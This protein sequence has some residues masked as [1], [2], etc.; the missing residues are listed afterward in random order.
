MLEIKNLHIETDNIKLL[1]GL[2][3]KVNKNEI[4]ILMGPNG[5]GKSTLCKTI[6]GHPAYKIIEG[7]IL[8]NGQNLIDLEIEKRANL[9]IFMGFQY[10]IEIPNTTNYAFLHKT[11]N[12]S[13]KSKNKSILSKKEFEELIDKKLKIVHLN[14]DFLSRGINEG[15]SGGEKKKFELLQMLLLDPQLIILDEIDSGLDIDAIKVVSQAIENNKKDKAIVIITHYNRL[16][17]YIKADY[18]HVIMNGK[19]VTTK[20]HDFAKTLEETGYKA[21]EL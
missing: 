4:H 8:F 10:P 17:D 12:I 15:F 16:L 1:D 11:V 21:L 3:L 5:M 13:R 7:S 14:K 19:I 9:G 6:I 18:V 2:N 20:G